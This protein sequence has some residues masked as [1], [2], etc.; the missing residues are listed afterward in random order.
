MGYEQ[1]CLHL[2][3]LEHVIEQS[4]WAVLSRSGCH[5]VSMEST[6]NPYPSAGQ[7]R[8][9]KVQIHVI[10]EALEEQCIWVID[11]SER[12]CTAFHEADKTFLVIT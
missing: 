1:Q 9:A 7:A 3:S 5:T 2:D 10:Q 12:Q 4:S 8:I 6:S 11:K